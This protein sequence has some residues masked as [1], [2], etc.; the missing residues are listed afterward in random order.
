M[1]KNGF[2]GLRATRTFSVTDKVWIAPS[3]K[4]RW[5]VY[6]WQESSFFFFFARLAASYPCVHKDFGRQD[7]ERSGAVFLF[8]LPAAHV[9]FG[10]YVQPIEGLEKAVL[11]AMHM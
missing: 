7:R 6:G 11:V 5:V 9:R 1:P 4:K 8:F 3:G 10:W 2:E